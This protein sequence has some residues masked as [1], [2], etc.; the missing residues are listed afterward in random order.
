VDKVLPSW[1]IIATMKSPSMSSPEPQCLPKAPSG[2]KGLDQITGG[3]LPRGRSTLVTGGPGCGKTLFGMEFLVRGIRDYDEPGV[4][5][6]FEETASELAQNVRALGF[7]LDALVVDRR[8]VLDHVHIER[9]EFEETGE[10]DLEGLF[11]RLAHAIDSIGAKRVVLDTLEA[12]LAGLPNPMLLRGELRRLMRWLKEKGV[13]A[14]ITAERG[15]GDM[16][17]HGIEEYV[18]DCVILLDQ[19]VNEQSTTRRL[20]VIKYRGSMHGNS[21]YPFLI[22]DA[23]ISVLPLTSVTLDHPASSERISTGVAGLDAMLGGHGYYRGSSILLSGTAGSGKSSISCHFADSA[24]GRG[25]RC[26]Y[27]AFEESQRQIA[28]NMRSI[29]LD[30]ERWVK[31]GLLRFHAVRP[32]QHGLETHLA[33]IHKL[34]QEFQPRVLVLD[35][36]SNMEAVGSEGAVKS[37]LSRLL[38]FLKMEQITTLCTSLTAGGDHP[39][40]SE[41]G[42]SSLMDTWILLQNRYSDGERNRLIYL[43]KS[44]GMAHS[45]QVREF[46]VTDNGVQLVDVCISPDGVLTGS[47]RIAYQARARAAALEQQLESERRG[48]ELARRREALEAKIAALRDEFAREEQAVQ[49]LVEAEQA[50]KDALRGERTELSRLRVSSDRARADGRDNIVTGGPEDGRTTG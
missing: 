38:D 34:V 39:E 26:L 12:V 11:I 30:L 32:T 29:G 2:I 6:S 18:S 3:G 1:G 15:E 31:A 42:V 14:V 24:C 20:R 47:A 50:R 27:L 43:L 16:T 28:R 21:L 7:D 46:L 48:D 13:T 44:R 41:V 4:F 40:R 49:R 5:M 36:V 8:L 23:G 17:R 35:P 45:N 33:I 9:T 19:F 25:E 22:D 10:F 37:M